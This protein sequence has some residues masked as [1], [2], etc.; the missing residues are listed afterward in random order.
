[1][2]GAFKKKHPSATIQLLIDDTAKV[3][4]A[5]VNNDLHIGVVGA[6]VSDPRLETHP[7]LKDE[8]VIAVP[9]G[10]QWPAGKPSASRSWLEN[11]YR[12]R[13]RFRAPGASWKKG[14]GKPNA[15]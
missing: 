5:I 14:S 6:R 10:H 1:M 7:F 9:A 11:L 2:I 3:S 15:R 4:E 13:E 8:L 12:A